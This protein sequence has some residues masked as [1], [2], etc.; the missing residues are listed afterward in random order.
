MKPIMRGADLIQAE[1][2]N[3]LEVADLVLCDVSLLNANV[4]FELG[5]R[6]ALDRPVA[7]V[8]D[9]KTATYPFDTSMINY[10]SYDSS[11]AAWHLSDEIAKLK[12]HIAE[13][14]TRADGRNS[15]W[16]Y[17]GLTK[18]AEP[19]EVDNPLERKVDLLLREVEKIRAS[20]GERQGSDMAT[21]ISGTQLRLLRAAVVASRG[22][23]TVED[24]HQITG[25]ALPIIRFGV[26]ILEERGNIHDTS[27]GWLAAS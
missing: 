14:A 26:E 6:T 4:F 22:P 19:A 24:L 16:Q 13:T 21:A 11:L 12:L 10:H 2:I 1:I 17:F 25:L 15:M 9:D 23:V 18:R 7:M 20:E 3:N 8:K 27:E 5:V